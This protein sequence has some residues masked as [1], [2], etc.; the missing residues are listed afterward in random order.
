V[1]TRP[2]RRARPLAQ[3]PACHRSAHRHPPT[4]AYRSPRL[5][6]HM[7]HSLRSL[8][9]SA[10]PDRVVSC[11]LS[12]VPQAER[13]A[14]QDE[15][16]LEPD[17]DL[18]MGIRNSDAAT[19]SAATCAFIHAAGAL[20]GSAARCACSRWS[21]RSDEVPERGAVPAGATS[22]DRKHRLGDDVAR[23]GLGPHDRRAQW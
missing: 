20:V 22:A 17:G 4:A 8:G 2:R 7:R 10:Q 14:G 19:L 11:R 5:T 16:L 3:Q 1:Q 6:T 15:E 12:T 9:T 21:R 13:H 23:D 18:R